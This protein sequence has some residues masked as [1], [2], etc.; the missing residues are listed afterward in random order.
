MDSGS[1]GEVLGWVYV[2]VKILGVLALVIYGGIHAFRFR[3]RQIEKRDGP[4]MQEGECDA[5]EDD[6]EEP[7]GG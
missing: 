6:S 4:P 3:Q 1:G 2:T 7:K 5:P